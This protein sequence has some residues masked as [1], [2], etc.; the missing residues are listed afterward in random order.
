MKKI[1][2][3]LGTVVLMLLLISGCAPQSSV[4]DQNSNI[5]KQTTSVTT[6]SNEIRFELLNKKDMNR[7]M[8]RTI[9]DI[10]DSRGF[11][12]VS[13]DENS[14]Y[15]YIGLGVNDLEVEIQKVEELG[16]K[17]V[18]TI[19]ENKGKDGSYIVLILSKDI[20]DAIEVV[21]IEGAQFEK[22]DGK[23][24]E[25]TK[26]GIIGTIKEININK[27]NITLI[28]EGEIDK[29]SEYDKANVRV[30][31]NTLILLNDVEI[32][33]DKLEMGMDVKVIF[34]GPVMESYPVQAYAKTVY[35]YSTN[36][37]NV[38]IPEEAI[39]VTVSKIEEY[40]GKIIL[41]TEEGYR[42][43]VD[44]NTKQNIGDVELVVGITIWIVLNDDKTKADPTDYYAEEI[45]IKLKTKYGIIGTIKEINI[46]EENIVLIVEGEINE[47]SE[48]DRANIRVDENTLILLN[49][50]E[51]SSDKLEL[52]MDVKVIFD[53]PVMESY[54][55][56]GYAETVYATSS[57]IDTLEVPEEAIKVNITKV[58]EYEGKLILST[59]E[60][61]RAKVDSNTILSIGDAELIV[62]L[63][64]WIVLN[65][66][67][68][69]AD[70]TDYYAEEIHIK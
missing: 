20:N 68:T 2:L 54:P 62:G 70:P 24:D 32:S 30:D 14:F 10:N 43:K 13:E 56:Q 41:S 5:T 58:E 37:D 23:K 57:E 36:I 22:I 53:G 48:Y 38:D 31:E 6:V 27:K 44:S 28:I 47:A 65:D 59:E 33:S 60:G 4:N 66:D 26:Y 9:E 29:A 15:I 7:D 12:I 51:I 39:E 34:D 40:E 25:E 8:I 45:Y 63:I 52:G 49:D 50:V 61:Y 67:K 69:K 17:T 21:N 64:V 42:A 55:V 1:Y 46:N 35:A 16:D 18:I 3:K 19:D 11:K